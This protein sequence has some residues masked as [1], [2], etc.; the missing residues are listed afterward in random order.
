[1]S[2]TDL[3]R[4]L[5]ER[6]VMVMVK[7]NYHH[8]NPITANLQS[9]MVKVIVITY[10]ILAETQLRV[11]TVWLTCNTGNTHYEKLA[12]HDIICATL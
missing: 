12:N 7:D 4:D 1:M 10:K 6:M 5:E 2:D 11:M 8:I 3:S 9:H